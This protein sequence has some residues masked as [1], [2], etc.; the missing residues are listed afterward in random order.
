MRAFATR[1]QLWTRH[2]GSL[3]LPV[4]G[5]RRQVAASASEI[6]KPDVKKLAKMAHIDVTDEEVRPSHV[7]SLSVDTKSVPGNAAAGPL[8][9]ADTLPVR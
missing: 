9:R 8:A 6:D 2:T 1:A 7:S 4:P 5:L 3:R